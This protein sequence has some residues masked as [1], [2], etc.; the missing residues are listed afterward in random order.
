MTTSTP[1]L[2]WTDELLV[3]IVHRPALLVSL[4]LS[5][6]VNSAMKSTRACA[7]MAVLGWY[8][9]SNWLSSIS[10][11]IILLAASGCFMDFLIG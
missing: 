4:S 11:W 3:W 9:M 6:D 5:G 1:L 8:S 10:Y 2:F 7:L